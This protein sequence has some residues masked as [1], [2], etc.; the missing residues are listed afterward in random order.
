LGILKRQATKLREG[1]YRGVVW[2][3]ETREDSL[4]VFFW[5]ERS[6]LF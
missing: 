1:V 2:Q 4:E 6:S 3:I 5:N